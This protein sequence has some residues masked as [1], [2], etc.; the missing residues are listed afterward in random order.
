MDILNTRISQESNV[1]RLIERDPRV[2]E[3]R[4]PFEFWYRWTAP[5]PQPLSASFELRESVRQ[6]RLTSTVLAIVAGSLFILAVPTSFATQNP[7][8]LVVLCILLFIVS[9]A[10]VLNRV[11]KGVWGRWTVVIAMNV[12]L[13]ISV[14]TWTGGLTTNTLPIFDIMVT[15][16]V[17]VALVLLPP[18]SVFL[19]MLFNV[20]FI[21]AAFYFLPYSADLLRVMSFDGYEVVT[22][23]LYL[24]VFVVGII[25]PVMR[26]VLR[27]I[28]LGDRA[29]EIAK[30]QGALADREAVI[31]LEKRQLDLDID[32]LARVVVLA[33]NGK[34]NVRLAPPVSHTLIPFA[35]SL[36]TLFFRFRRAMRGEYQL[37]HTIEAAEML[38]KAL[39]QSRRTQTPLPLKRTGNPIIDNII[40]ELLVG[41]DCSADV[42][43]EYPDTFLKGSGIPDV[44]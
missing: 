35:G 31:A 8:L 42:T 4:G 27:A 23:P 13:A 21:A 17:L 5:H 16:P 15:E 34:L 29:K 1:V 6:G 26:S 44:R 19:V 40:C 32:Q 41:R 10:L 12:A 28:A 11:G 14:V 2:H 7:V 39:Q 33:A 36:N 3:E 9:I 30:V 25:Y 37:Q 20:I 43:C 24:L 18:A 22:R 38:I